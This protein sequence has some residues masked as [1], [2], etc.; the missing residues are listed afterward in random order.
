MSSRWD[1]GLLLPSDLNLDISS[2]ESSACR[3]QILG[4]VSF[5]LHVSLFLIINDIWFCF[6]GEPRLL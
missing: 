2:P 6:S 1:I 3:L 4:L 5:N